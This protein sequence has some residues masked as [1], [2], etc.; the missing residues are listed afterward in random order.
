M[1]TFQVLMG[2]NKNDVMCEKLLYTGY[3]K[4]EFH[5][6]FMCILKTKFSSHGWG[7]Y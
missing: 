4:S 3:V 1:L 2:T 6:M 5:C 7:A